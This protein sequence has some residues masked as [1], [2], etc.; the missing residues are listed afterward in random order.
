VAGARVYLGH[1][2]DR[3]DDFAARVLEPALDL[4]EL[5]VDFVGG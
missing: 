2:L 4:F 5:S 1:A 3:F